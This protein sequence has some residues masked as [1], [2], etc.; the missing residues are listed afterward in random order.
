M[1]TTVCACEGL[2]WWCWWI[3]YVKAA[4]C[5][6]GAKIASA[7]TFDSFNHFYTCMQIKCIKRYCFLFHNYYHT[8]W[9][10]ECVCV[11]ARLSALHAHQP[12]F[13]LPKHTENWYRWVGPQ[14]AIDIGPFRFGRTTTA[15]MVFH[16]MCIFASGSKMFGIFRPFLF[17]V[18]DEDNDNDSDGSTTCLENK[19]VV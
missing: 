4:V 3:V 16:L 6:F 15:T 14:H 19:S 11:R 17:N 13:V 5:M 2:R 10:S 1:T 8:E 9:V 12:S 7:C 18:D